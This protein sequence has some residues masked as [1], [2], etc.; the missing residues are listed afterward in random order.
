MFLLALEA[1]VLALPPFPM[2]LAQA[3]FNWKQKPPR[4]T[5]PQFPVPLDLASFSQKQKPQKKNPQRQ[6]METLLIHQV[7]MMSLLNYLPMKKNIWPASKHSMKPHPNGLLTTYEITRCVSFYP[8][9]EIMKN[10]LTIWTRNGK[11][12][13]KQMKNQHLFPKQN[14][15]QQLRVSSSIPALLLPL[16]NRLSALRTQL[17]HQHRVWPCSTSNP[18]IQL[19]QLRRRPQL[20]QVSQVYSHLEPLMS[21]NLRL[22]LQHL[23]PHFLLDLLGNYH[24]LSLIFA[25]IF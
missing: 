14:Q 4:K 15:Q 22:E 20:H 5:L 19:R 17:Q 1:L 12:A 9:F 18:P 10:T 13:K 25:L 8:F 6:R 11:Q 21:Q 24:D 2:P 23:L 16:L 7:V 3:Y